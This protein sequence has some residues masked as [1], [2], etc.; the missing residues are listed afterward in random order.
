MER[1]NFLQTK[2]SKNTVDSINTLNTQ[3]LFNPY[4]I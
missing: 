2:L 4:V 3:P 1:Q